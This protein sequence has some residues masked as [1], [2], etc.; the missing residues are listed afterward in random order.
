MGAIFFAIVMLHLVVGF[1]YV[2]F[3][4]KSKGE[5]KGGA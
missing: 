4:L 5:G 1:G 3:K 2:M